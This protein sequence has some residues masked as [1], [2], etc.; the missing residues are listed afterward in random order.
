ML[1]WWAVCLRKASSLSSG[2]AT[3]TAESSIESLAPIETHS[4]AETGLVPRE[5]DPRM[6][7]ASSAT[8]KIRDLS[9]GAS[10]SG[11]ERVV[12]VDLATELIAVED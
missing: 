6:A 4:V 7:M 2:V 11:Q 5:G 3:E 10:S 12:H 9:P 1:L 8:V